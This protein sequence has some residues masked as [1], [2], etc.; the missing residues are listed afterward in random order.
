MQPKAGDPKGHRDHCALIGSKFDTFKYIYLIPTITRLKLTY[1]QLP[2]ES[3]RV[4]E[5]KEFL[6]VLHPYDNDSA[7]VP[8]RPSRVPTI[9]YLASISWVSMSLTERKNHN[10]FWA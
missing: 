7:Y 8:S 10:K 6:L 2:K 5:K 1:I 3:R 9:Y 4:L